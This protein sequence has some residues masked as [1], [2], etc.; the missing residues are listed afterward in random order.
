MS[1]TYNKA[2][3]LAARNKIKSANWLL[4]AS[5][6]EVSRSL[7]SRQ[8]NGF[9]RLVATVLSLIFFHLFPYLMIAAYMSWEGFFSYDMFAE[10]VSGLTAFYWWAEIFVVIASVYMLGALHFPVAYVLGKLRKAPHRSGEFWFVG[11]FNV[12]IILGLVFSGFGPPKGF[13][14][15]HIAWLYGVA[16]WIV[17]HLTILA[18][19]TGRSALASLVFGS[20]GLCTLAAV[21]PGTLALPYTMSLQ[22]FG[23]GGGLKARAVLNKDGSVLEGSLVLA[24]PQHLYLYPTGT[25]SLTAIPRRDVSLLTVANLTGFGHTKAASK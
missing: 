15:N 25:T 16:A 2:T 24:T 14:L 1:Y 7:T 22:Y 20:V 8:R 21:H 3:L 9:S 13:S 10:G 6:R 17:I 12:L 5:G 4:R 23:N 19:G 11:S 18:Y